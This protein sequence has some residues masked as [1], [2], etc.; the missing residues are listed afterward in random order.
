MVTRRVMSAGN[1]TLIF[2]VA[3]PDGRARAAS[4]PW[5]QSLASDAAVRKREKGKRG[6]RNRQE[7]QGL[8]E[9]GALFRSRPGSR[10]GS[11]PYHVS[12]LHAWGPG[13]AAAVEREGR[14]QRRRRVPQGAADG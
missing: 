4:R 3:P 9:H 8:G 14:D 6:A 2:E 7:K 13:G 10:P 12:S 1:S 11:L 5:P